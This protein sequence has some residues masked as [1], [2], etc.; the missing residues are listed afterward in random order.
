MFFYNFM[1]NLPLVN[2]YKLNWPVTSVLV[3]IAQLVARALHA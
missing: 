2:P 1:L 3:F